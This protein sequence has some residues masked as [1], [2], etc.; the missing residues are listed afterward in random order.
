[1][2]NPYAAYHFNA[3]AAQRDPEADKA[4]KDAGWMRF[5][6]AVAPAAGTAVGAGAGALIGGLPTGGVGALP[7][8]AIGSALGGAAG[9]AVG[10]L[11]GAG[12]EATLDPIRKRELRR[13]ELMRLLRGG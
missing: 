7:G 3:A 12:A 13:Q 8:M 5:L 11:A 2:G 9:T 10:G 6:A 4:E 1:M